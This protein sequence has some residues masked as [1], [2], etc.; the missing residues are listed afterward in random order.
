VPE[1]SFSM[2]E[3]QFPEVSFSFP[4]TELLVPETQFTFPTTE[5]QTPDVQFSFPATEWKGF[6]GANWEVSFPQTA[7]YGETKPEPGEAAPEATSGNTM[8][9]ELL[10]LMHELKSDMQELRDDVRALRDDVKGL[11]PSAP[12]ARQVSRG[13]R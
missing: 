3:I 1:L 7:L 11:E 10:R 8:L 4:P 13:A 9:D 5:L 2:P 6:E 12:K